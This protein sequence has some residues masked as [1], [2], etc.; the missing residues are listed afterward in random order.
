MACTP[1]K[2]M[3]RGR[4]VASPRTSTAIVSPSLT[5]TAR[6]FHV[7]AAAAAGSSASRARESSSGRI[8]AL[9]AA[10]V[11]PVTS[12]LRPVEVADLPA[13]YEQQADPESTAMAAVPARTRGDFMAHWRRI[14][15]DD[16]AVLRA[17]LDGGRLAGHVTCWRDGD[18]RLVGYWIDRAQWGRGLATRALAALLDEVDERPLYAH[19]VPHNAASLRVLE[20]C[21][22]EAVDEGGGATVVLVLTD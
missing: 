9:S 15:A 19:V 11:G 17:V 14:M 7:A 4:L 8:D 3:S 6:P 20:K 10:T 12:L 18:R 16:T 5:D 13:L 1:M 2:R 22:F 21:G